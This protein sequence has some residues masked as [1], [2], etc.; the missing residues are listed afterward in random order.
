MCIIICIFLLFPVDELKRFGR[1]LMQCKSYKERQERI[2]ESLDYLSYHYP[3]IY[4]LIVREIR[5]REIESNDPNRITKWSNISTSNARYAKLH[6]ALMLVN[7]NNTAAKERYTISLKQ[8]LVQTIEKKTN[9]EAA[10][11]ICCLI[12]KS[13]HLS[14]IYE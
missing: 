10:V 5:K 8:L 3:D 2:I 4:S 13:S 7:P 6:E 1:A 12:E 14:I 11:K 9:V